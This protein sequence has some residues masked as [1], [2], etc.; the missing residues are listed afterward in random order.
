MTLVRQPAHEALCAAIVEVGKCATARALLRDHADGLRPLLA[1]DRVDLERRAAELEPRLGAVGAAWTAAEAAAP[2]PLGR[3]AAAAG[4]TEAVALLVLAA[5]IDLDRAMQRTLA[6]LTAE[7][8]LTAGVLVDLAAPTLPARLA[9]MGALH[10]TAPLRRAGLLTIDEP[11]ARA[12]A[13]VEVA[14]SVLAAL[15]GEPVAPPRGVL[16]RAAGDA[17]RARRALAAAGVPLLQPGELTALVG[18]PARAEQL[19][20]QLAHAAGAALWLHAPPPGAA[21]EDDD[22]IWT[23]AWVEGAAL[24]VDLRGPRIARAAAA[25]EACARHGALAIALVDADGA[26]RARLTVRAV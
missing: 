8:V 10:A 7:R 25:A 26:S 22:A 15:R 11:V 20:V 19:A 23:D 21:P 16:V 13:R 9:L 12:R 2:G 18:A 5:A 17:A 6:E 3:I 24:G 4:S 1:R 14:P